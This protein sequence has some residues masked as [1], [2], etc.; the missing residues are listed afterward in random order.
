MT[1]RGTAA[2]LCA[3]LALSIQ[4]AG[5]AAPAIGEF[6]L[7]LAGG[8]PRVAPGTD[9]YGHAGGTWLASEQIPSDRTSWGPF[10]KLAEQTDT[11]LRAILD[12]AAAN[13]GRPGSDARRMVDF[14]ASF[15]DTE[16][17]EARGL[18]PAA[19]A[20]AAIDAARTHEDI[21]RLMGR[22]DLGLPAPI[23]VS[24]S[25]DRKNPDRYVVTVTHGGLSL[26]DRDFYLKDDAEFAGLRR[27]FRDHVERL[28]ALGGRLDPAAAA[29]AIL[30]LETE[31]ARLHWPRAERRDRDRTY[32]PRT[33][34][35]LASLA[36]D[37]PW[38]AQFRAA[39]LGNVREVVVAE[40]SAIGPLAK[41]FR[42]TPV[43]SWRAYLSYQYLR[44]RA[45]VLTHA[46]DVEVF[47]FYGLVLS[48][49]PEL[50]PRWRRAIDATNG[51]MG[52]AVGR[53]YAARHFPPA[54]REQAIA[55]V[56]RLRTAYA[57]R[58]AV[59]PWMSDTS[60]AA[61]AGKLAAIRLKI[62]YPDRWR[63]YHALDVRRD[64]AFGNLTRAA[65]FEWHREIARLGRPADRDEW[66]ATPQTVNAYYNPVF[67]EIV[68]PAAILQPP[69][70]DPAADAAVNY[71][72]IGGVIGHELGHGFDDQGA[73]SDARGVLQP[74]WTP[75]DVTAFRALGDRLAA[76]YDAFEALP[77]IHVNGRLTLGENIG[78][79]GGLSAA[80]EA[81]R[82]SLGG[83]PTPVLGGL[84][85]EQRFFLAWAQ[86]WR[87]LDRSEL[88]R[89]LLLSDP[90]S[91]SR[92]R[93]NGVVRNMDAWY[94]AFGVKPGDP[95]YLAPEARVHI[96]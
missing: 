58:L 13:P 71:G 35:E 74:W 67:N 34:A 39:E 31:I 43:A 66:F 46:L 54:A 91:P 28:L 6:G 76:Q 81:Y 47:G 17:I 52:E 20:L 73:K 19:P 22:G 83:Q 10:A 86:V 51:A 38:D 14:Y 29:D 94:E 72:A 12:A 89:N 2:R 85:G 92:Y 78:D 87:R 33:R 63:D 75:A 64:D 1:V 70:F 23:D 68:V 61:A 25:L 37:Y 9:F 53:E 21:A 49:Q 79:L 15:L 62:G 77:G 16:A 36:P 4:V 5:A 44:A 26:P 84:S 96:W 27:Q 8:D 45:R 56:E 69:F 55:L 50:K 82:L 11:D 24:I 59:V 32:N 3:A 57:T 93:V 48:G 42:A 95:L 80:L 60:R 40:L 18:A 90:H 88:L 65:V 7:D 41:L 30:A